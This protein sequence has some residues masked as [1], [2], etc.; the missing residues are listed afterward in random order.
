MDYI[1]KISPQAHEDIKIIRDYIL[2]DGQDVADRQAAL[3]YDGIENLAIFLNAGV[4]LS[5]RVE[6][7]TNYRFIVIQKVYLAFYK[8]IDKTIYVSR[9]FRGEQDYIALLG[10]T[11][12]E[13]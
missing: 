2:K 1:V 6:R 8:I 12:N 13:Q 5:K 7:E 10:L 3:I 11:K 4:D 9:V